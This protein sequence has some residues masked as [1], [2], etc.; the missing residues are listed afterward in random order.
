MTLAGLLLTASF[1]E[2]HTLDRKWLIEVGGGRI[3]EGDV[4]ILTEAYKGDINGRR[5]K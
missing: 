1:I 4:S 2:L 5:V 3:V